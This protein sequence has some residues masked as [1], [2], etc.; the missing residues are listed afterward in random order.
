M[1]NVDKISIDFASRPDTRTRLSTIGLAYRLMAIGRLACWHDMRVAQLLRSAPATAGGGRCGLYCDVIGER[2]R[3]ASS[4]RCFRA[5][6]A[7]RVLRSPGLGRGAFVVTECVERGS[8]SGVVGSRTCGAGGGVPGTTRDHPR[9]PVV[10]RV[11]HSEYARLRPVARRPRVPRRCCVPGHHGPLRRL[12]CTRA[13]LAF[14]QHAARGNLGVSR[15][16]PGVLGAYGGELRGMVKV[17]EGSW[18]PLR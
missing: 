3:S 15:E 5:A 7:R 6:G 1:S 11:D 18:S 13:P 16:G 4:T 9:S 12:R 8:S 10:R 17:S 2:G 14:L